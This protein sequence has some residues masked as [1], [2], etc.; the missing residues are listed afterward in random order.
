M[1]SD[2]HVSMSIGHMYQ[3]NTLDKNCDCRRGLI[4]MTLVHI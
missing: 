3:M 4:L 2:N 1:E